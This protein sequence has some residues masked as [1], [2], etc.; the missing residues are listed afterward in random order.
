[1]KKA[2]LFLILLSVIAP[3]TAFPEEYSL[4]DLYNLAIQRSETIRIAEEDVF[5]SERDKDRAMA[6]LFPKLSAFGS[7]TQYNKERATDLFVI[8]PD[9]STSWGLN[10]KQSL[11]LSGKE[12]TALRIAKESIAKN[13]YDLGAVKESYLLSVASAY[14]DVLRA[15]KAL[16]IANANVERL[17]K[18]RNASRT[19]LRVGEIT[20]TVLLRAEAELSGAQS[21]LIK[22]EN[23]L[24]LAKAV[25]ARTAGIKGDYDVREPEAGIQSA[26]P[27]FDFTAITGDCGMPVLDCLKQTALSGRSEIKSVELQKEIDGQQVKYAKGSYWPDISVQGVYSR[28][29][30]DPSLAF[31][32]KESVYGTIR[33]DYPFFEGGLRKAEVSQAKARFRQT[34]YRLEDAYKSV[35]VEV[36]NAYLNLITSSGILEKLQ[37]EAEYAADNYNAVTKQFEF[38]L[39][40]SLDVMDA[41]TL[42][43]TSEKQL[44]NAKYDYQYAILELKRATGTFLK[45][46][47][48]DQ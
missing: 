43:V 17:T 28:L 41:N 5:I 8:Q 14:Y 2:I 36:E 34:D 39:A 24:K 37:A 21:D 11:S 15:R 10:V 3:C 45:A 7:Y 4:D 42:L 18:H 13:G 40:D 25:L 22:A 6:V 35:S 33:I 20:K 23:G 30:N 29:E 27:T 47:S 19:R 9:N 1:M 26:P 46:V 44:A 38:G 48:G 12:F 31:E 32:I 16:D